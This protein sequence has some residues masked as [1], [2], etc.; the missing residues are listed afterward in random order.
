M[1]FSDKIE[2]DS[3]GLHKTTVLG[4]QSRTIVIYFLVT[5]K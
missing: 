5:Y 3:F 4:E 2:Y 1:L